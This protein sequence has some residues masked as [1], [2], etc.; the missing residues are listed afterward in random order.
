MQKEIPEFQP[1]QYY[2]VFLSEDAAEVLNGPHPSPQAVEDY[3][4][5]LARQQMD[6]M[7]EP[8]D[9]LTDWFG[10]FM[11]VEKIKEASVLVE[12]ICETVN[13]E[14]RGCA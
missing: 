3:L 9:V 2:A 14:E 8:C 4:R 13:S 10:P 7:S 6:D 1:R 11:V 12:T 5:N